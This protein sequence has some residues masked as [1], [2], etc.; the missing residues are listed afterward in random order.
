M[1]KDNSKITKYLNN[2]NVNGIYK[3]LPM[4]E[5]GSESIDTYISSLILEL[6]GMSSLIDDEFDEFIALIS[7][8]S[9][10]KSTALSSNDRDSSHIVIKRE[11][12]KAIDISKKLARR[13]GG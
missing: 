12:F 9:G 13:V 4:Y 7:V 2:R 6:N 3:I 11:V 10:I 8:L 1:K 5:E